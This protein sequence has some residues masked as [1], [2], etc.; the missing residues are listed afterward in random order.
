[1]LVYLSISLAIAGFMNRYNR[2]SRCEEPKRDSQVDP[3]NADRSGAALATRTALFELA[4]FVG[5]A[6]NYLS[7]LAGRASAARM[8]ARGRNLV[9][10][11]RR[12]LPSGSR[13]RRLLGIHRG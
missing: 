13:S 9:A 10:P 12:A 2:A 1:M 4:E 3:R 7:R 6:G 8:G 5:D 11:R